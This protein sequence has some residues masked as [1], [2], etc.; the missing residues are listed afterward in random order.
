[1]TLDTASPPP[2]RRIS[3]IAL[4]PL[5][6]FAALAA[7]FLRQLW[8]G[9]DPSRLPSPLI[10]RAAPEFDLPGI[11]GLARDGQPVAGLKSADLKGGVSVVN[12]WG[13]WC[14]E[15]REEHDQLKALGADTR[16]RLVGITW[17]D[18]PAD[19]RRYLGTVGN[20]FA[21]VGVDSTGR[22]AIDWGV[23]G[24]PETFVVGKDGKV[25]YKFIGPL[26]PTSLHDVLMPEIAKALAAS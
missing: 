4:L 7:V 18:Q 21:A 22:A 9:V 10:G 12:I 11:E 26:T 1:M 15:C 5:I 3:W 17:R 13:S 23:Y 20:P 25:T 6:L 16:F 19:A 24:V 2:T 14:V 8:R